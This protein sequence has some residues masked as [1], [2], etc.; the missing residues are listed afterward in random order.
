V[1]RELLEGSLAKTRRAQQRAGSSK[2]RAADPTS[3]R[4][5]A[6]SGVTSCLSATKTSSAAKAFFD[7]N[8]LLHMFGGMDLRKQERAKELVEQHTRSGRLLLSTQ[9]VQFYWALS[10][11][12]GMPHGAGRCLARCSSFRW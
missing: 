11:K 10:R 5:L 7:A 1:L 9:V 12:V 6:R 3:S 8:I 2:S 4:T